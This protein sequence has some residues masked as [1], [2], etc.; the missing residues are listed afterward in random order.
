ML[1]FAIANQFCL[2]SMQ[3][4]ACTYICLCYFAVQNTMR[5]I[6]PSYAN[7]AY[8]YAQD[9]RRLLMHRAENPTAQQDH[10]GNIPDRITTMSLSN[11]STPF[12][13]TQCPSYSRLV[14]MSDA[15]LRSMLYKEIYRRLSAKPATE[16]L[17]AD[18]ISASSTGTVLDHYMFDWPAWQAGT[19][20]T[21]LC[22]VQHW[23]KSMHM[24]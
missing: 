19:C 3:Y 18:A 24:S 6:F 12:L 4:N 8:G 21:I 11:F 14:K 22:G 15:R 9:L 5:P 1:T 7:R 13:Y 10:R 2:V 17:I 23:Y 20:A 16:S